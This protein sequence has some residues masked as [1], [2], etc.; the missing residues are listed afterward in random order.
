M[1]RIALCLICALHVLLCRGVAEN[2]V[3]APAPECAAVCVMEVQGRR[4]LYGY[5]E[6][7]RRQVAGVQQLMT[8]LCVA[9]AGNLDKLVMIEAVDCRVHP[10]RLLRRGEQHSRRELLQVML[11]AGGNDVVHALARDC[12]G[13]EASFVAR[14]NRR[15]AELGMRQTC[16]A[17]ATGQPAEQYSTAAD[18]ALLAC[19]VYENE[20]LRPMGAVQQ[21]ELSLPQGRRQFRNTNRLLFDYPRVKGMK[22]GYSAFA[23][24]CLVACG[25]R[26]GRTVV[27]VVLG[28][29]PRK[30][31]AESLKY[32]NW[33]L[34]A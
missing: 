27:V 2:S 23:G 21:Y 1:E 8:A 22:T 28:S 30:V 25:V 13:D 34:E 5:K 11:V 33:A 29:L 19:Q 15:A 18:M 32:L 20:I 31:W 10:L 12:A 4:M 16:F 3:P 26:N 6:N 7:D 17:N 9:D 14:M 24:K